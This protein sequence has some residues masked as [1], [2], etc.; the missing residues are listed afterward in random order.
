MRTNLIE[1]IMGAV[2]LAVAVFFLVFAYTSSRVRPNG[3]NIFHARFDRVDGLKIG[4]D[5]RM[6]GVKVG[7][8]QKVRIDPKNFFALVELSVEPQISL[9]KDTSAEIVTDGFLGGKYMALVPGGDDENIK[10]GGDIIYTQ[11]SVSLEA[12][13]G[14]LIFNN[15][16]TKKEGDSGEGKAGHSSATVP[17][18]EASGPSPNA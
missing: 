13:I 11:S 9:P 12:M 15:K 16:S 4:S 2:V 1:T 17:T 14:Q 18:T 8:V 6:S 3:G 10:P 5:V 7:S